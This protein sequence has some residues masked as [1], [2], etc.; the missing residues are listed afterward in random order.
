MQRR[1]VP[2]LA[3]IMA[4]ALLVPLRQGTAATGPVFSD[5]GPDAAGYG[6]GQ[7]YPTQRGG[8]LLPQR[9]MV[10]DYSHYDTLWPS[11]S[12]AKAPVPSELRRSADEITLSYQY[13]GVNYTLDDY[14]DRNPTTGLLIARDD[15]ILFEHY[16]YARTDH[17]RFLSQSMAKTVTAMLLGIAVSEGAIHS[18]DEPAADYVPEL[19]GTR[20]RQHDDPRAIAHV[21]RRRVY[22]GLQR[23]R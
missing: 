5:T 18:I 23:Q 20:I 4:L 13:Q 17:D 7:G 8:A 6:S 12:V 1:T 2:W 21:F 15:T 10:G 11:H 22:R 19:A 3:I 16:R 9:F 14:L